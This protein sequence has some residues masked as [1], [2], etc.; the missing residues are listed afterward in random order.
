MANDT[1]WHGQEKDADEGEQGN[2]QVA[3]RRF[4]IEVPITHSSD[5][6]NGEP[7]GMLQGWDIVLRLHQIDDGGGEEHHDCQHIREHL[8]HCSGVQLGVQPCGKSL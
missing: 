5:R 8:D 1:H 7:K 2:N 3:P 4:W 6:H